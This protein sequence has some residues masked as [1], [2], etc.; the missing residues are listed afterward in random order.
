MDFK[1][2]SI[3]D[4]SEKFGFSVFIDKL[5]ACTNGTAS[6][7]TDDV[8]TCELGTGAWLH[9]SER[10]GKVDFLPP[11][12]HDG[13]HTVV[14]IKHTFQASEGTFY[15]TTYTTSIWLAILGLLFF[16]AGLKLFDKHFEPSR[17]RRRRRRRESNGESRNTNWAIQ[18]QVFLLKAASLRRLRK[19]LQCTGANCLLQFSEE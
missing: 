11:F 9:N 14:N 2:S 19:A 6:R 13:M 1:C 10:Y 4:F 12:L 15:L 3:K 17:V 8:C 7:S 16:F 5:H 18:L